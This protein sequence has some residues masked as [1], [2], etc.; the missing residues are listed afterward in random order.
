[1]VEFSPR[2][3]DFVY[4]LYVLVV[5]LAVCVHNLSVRSLPSYLIIVP[6][7]GCEAICTG[8]PTSPVCD[9]TRWASFPPD[10]V[11][12]EFEACQLCRSRNQ[13]SLA[14]PVQATN[15]SAVA[16]LVLAE[17]EP[18]LSLRQAHLGPWTQVDEEAALSLKA[19]DTALFKTSAAQYG[20]LAGFAMKIGAWVEGRDAT[21]YNMADGACVNR[22][23]YGLLIG[24]GFAVVFAVGS[25]P[26]GFVCHQKQRVSVVC[27]ALLAWSLATSMQAAAH[28]FSYMLG[29]R[30]VTGFA[31]A[32][33]MPALISL[34]IDLFG[35]SHHIA[36]AVL[37]VG[38]YLGS[39]CS[40]FA[41]LL[42]GVWGWRWVV[43]LSGVVGMVLS[44][45]IFLTV[46]EPERTRESSHSEVVA[47]FHEVFMRSQARVAR[48]LSAAA[49]AKMLAAYCL[50][51]YLPL[52]YSR[53][54][55]PG[56]SD[57]IYAGWN[58]IAISAGGLLSTG[59]GWALGDF[60]GR[61]DVR[62]PC[63]IGLASAS[64]SLPLVCFMLLAKT[65]AQSMLGFFML[66]LVSECWF[67][68]AVALLQ[69]SVRKSV[70]R[71]SVSIFLVVS[72]LAAN[73]GPAL[74][75]FMDPGD[76]RVGGQL[77]WICVTAN[78]GAA[79]AFLATAREIGLDPVAIELNDPSNNPK[80]VEA[81]PGVA[82]PYIPE[83]T[84]M[85]HWGLG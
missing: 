60:W 18:R 53:K 6:V 78:I 77:L 52:Y 48:L 31:Q 21:F 7:P 81:V 76:E 19:T 43:L 20:S 27:L 8:V 34:V 32:F 54:E 5:L 80:G 64:L 15:A 63:W 45:L 24:Y 23:E 61:R 11:P 85:A 50:G 26:A 68:P 71:Q 51:S 84:G 4:R 59:F 55:L 74:V 9:P 38:L 28:N 56:Y 35:E 82:H 30:S 3:K 12:T 37:S 47:V 29:C 66:L 83:R 10:V 57:N 42:A 17:E 41:V 62:A 70:S 72:S 16:Q 40:S 46:A 36:I 39:G 75:G 14:G 13:R 1:M 49:S 22:W 2:S 69:S 58:M 65:F 73:L 44:L 79:A 33:A 25:V 67:V